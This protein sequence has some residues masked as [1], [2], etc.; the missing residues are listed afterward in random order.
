M[1]AALEGLEPTGDLTVTRSINA[2]N[3]YDWQVKKPALFIPEEMIECREPNR[4]LVPDKD[5]GP[6]K[7]LHTKPA[8]G[9]WLFLNVGYSAMVGGSPVRVEAGSRTNRMPA[10]KL[11]VEML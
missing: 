3:G 11:V 1:E 9:G 5:I 7:C 2:N 6:L 10:E 8:S 4:N